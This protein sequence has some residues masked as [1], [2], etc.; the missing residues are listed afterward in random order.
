MVVLAYLS[1]HV[2][3]NIYL[4]SEVE[5]QRLPTSNANKWAL[6]VYSFNSVVQSKFLFFCKIALKRIWIFLLTLS[7]FSLLLTFPVNKLLFNVLKSLNIYPVKFTLT[8]FISQK[9][10]KLRHL[11]TRQLS[12]M[13]TLK[14]L[15]QHLQSY[16]KL[17][18]S[19][20]MILWT[21]NWHHELWTILHFVLVLTFLTLHK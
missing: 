8:T 2:K 14:H 15:S 19:T 21:F 17:L 16:Q 18:Q 6:S 11:T 13:K 10:K 3:G 5:S 12:A 20:T 1:L 7:L 9:L 4:K